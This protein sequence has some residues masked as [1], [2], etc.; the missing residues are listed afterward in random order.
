MKKLQQLIP[1]FF[2]L[3][4]EIICHAQNAKIDSLKAVLK[5]VKE[6]TDKVNTLNTVA[7]ELRGLNPDTSI[8]LSSEALMIAEK[9]KWMW[10]IGN[11][12]KFLGAFSYFKGDY[13]NAIIYYSK[14]LKI[15]DE[16]DSG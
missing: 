15:Y 9:N 11:S 2:L 12:D 5:I 3:L 1:L 8:I 4:V 16:L 10:G 14:A 7:W 13:P 6:D